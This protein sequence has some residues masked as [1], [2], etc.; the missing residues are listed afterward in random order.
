MNWMW[1]ENKV[2]KWKVW[3][4]LKWTTYTDQGYNWWNLIFQETEEH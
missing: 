2:D 1:G 4:T 3:P